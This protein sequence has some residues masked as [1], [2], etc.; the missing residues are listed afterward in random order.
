MT[1]KLRCPFMISGVAFALLLFAAAPA[2]AQWNLSV[3][4][5]AYQPIGF[6]SPGYMLSVGVGYR[7]NK[8]ISETTSLGYA[9]YRIESRDKIKNVNLIPATETFTVDLLPFLPV[10]P[11]VDTGVGT[12]FMGVAGD[13]WKISF[14]VHGGVGLRI[15]FNK[16]FGL[17][18]HGGYVVPD[19]KDFNQGAW[20]YGVNFGITLGGL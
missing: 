20:I 19:V 9:I 7:F 8:W 10:D 6:G 14:G 4:G 11:Y 2:Q 16:F 15:D 18:L 1:A 17:D 13:P 5:S 12:Y 3:S